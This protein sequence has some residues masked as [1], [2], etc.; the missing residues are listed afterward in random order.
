MFVS[1]SRLTAY[2]EEPGTRNKE[3]IEEQ[4]AEEARGAAKP[5]RRKQEIW[6]RRDDAD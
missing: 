6:S 3:Q 5:G 4:T 1:T 2:Y